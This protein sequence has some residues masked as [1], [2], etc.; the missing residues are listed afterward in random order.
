VKI[1]NSIIDWLDE[2]TGL[3]QPI[4]DTLTHLC[5]PGSKWA[6]VFGS[7]V[8][9]AFI[10]QLVTGVVLTTTYIPSA[11]EAYETVRYISQV[12]LGHFI[13]AMHY[14]GASAMVLFAVIHM[15]Q[16]Y[17]W[18]SYKYP[19]ELNWLSGVALFFFVILMGFTGQVLRWDQTAVWTVA[20]GAEQAM[21]AP[22]V[23][24]YI[25]EILMSG[26][27]VG[28][29]TLSHFFALHVF[30][31]PGIVIAV[32]GLHLWLVLR[33][34]ISEPPVV[35]EPVDPK[36][37]KEKYHGMLQRE[38]KP[39]WPDAAWRDI[40]FSAIIVFGIVACALCFGPPAIEKPPDPALVNAQPRPDWYLV[41][42]FALL[43]LLPHA[44]ENYIIIL[45][46][47]LLAVSLFAVPFLNN[48]GERNFRKRPWS[49]AIVVCAM[50]SVVALTYEGFKEPWTPKFEAVPLTNQIIGT[51]SGAIYD[52]AKVFNDKG[53]LFC[54]TISGHGGARGPDLTDVADRLTHEQMVVRIVNG[55]YNM[56]AY[57]GTLTP[58]E[59]KDVVTFLESRTTN[60]PIKIVISETERARVCA[61]AQ[62]GMTEIKLGELAASKGDSAEVRS[63]GTKMVTEHRQVG[64]ELKAA[65]AAAKVTLP[66]DMNEQQQTMFAELSKL[67]G[68]AF[69]DKYM[70]E[71]VEA[72]KNAVAAIGEESKEGSGE[73]KAWAEQTLVTIK[74]HHHLAKQVTGD[75][76]KK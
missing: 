7:A 28:G 72:H 34:G 64:D 19:R 5:P 12:P 29:A 55:G 62:D 24:K 46:P 31:F 75:G 4:I 6:Y 56:P 45:F 49:I 41:W 37:Y 13:R 36:T 11:G 2:R 51:T 40:V 60:V 47:L 35:G 3:K 17:L 44:A 71:I 68:K 63:F 33:N 52:G 48:K 25:A 74:R 69:D 26:T 30:I 22:F 73:L 27:T 43:A 20:V 66:V 50:S 42:Y 67:S 53:C 23:G 59:L 70:S 58:K 38:G 61:I 16:V 14:F 21:R 8:L 76:D 9:T 54:H 15:I 1:V 65:A 57:A 32:I 39:F 18:G 10:V